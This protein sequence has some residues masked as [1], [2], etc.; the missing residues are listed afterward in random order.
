MRQLRKTTG[1]DKSSLAELGILRD[2][3]LCT[4]QKCASAF[5]GVEQAVADRIVDDPQ[6]A[7]AVF[8]ERQRKYECRPSVRKRHRSVNRVAHPRV[9][10]FYKLASLFADKRV[11]GVLLATGLK[12][13]CVYFRSEE[14]R[15]GKEWRSR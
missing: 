4:V 9:L 1:L 13:H 2:M 6:N 7:L 12:Q 11:R 14:R 10:A 15:V 5:L 8:S 3:Y